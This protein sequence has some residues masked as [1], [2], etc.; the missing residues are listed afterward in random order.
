MTAINW[1]NDQQRPSWDDVLSRLQV[2]KD[3]PGER[4][5]ALS[6]GDDDHLIAYYTDYG[7]LVETH[8]SGDVDYFALVDNSRGAE[9]LS[10]WVAGDTIDR[11][12][13]AFVDEDDAIQ[14][15][16][17]YFETGKKN[18]ALTWEVNNTI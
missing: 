15:I 14:A 1:L 8:S 9:S 3:H 4:S 7:F 11:P 16:R 6:V 10:V 5:I 18:P 13:K 17:H 2:I 12:L